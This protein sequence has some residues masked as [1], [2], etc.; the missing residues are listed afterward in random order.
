MEQPERKYGW[1]RYGP[2]TR[3]MIAGLAINAI[4][5]LVLGAILGEVGAFLVAAP[6]ALLALMFVGWAFAGP[7]IDDD[8]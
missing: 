3:V 5:F 8:E 1:D 7:D 4:V 6:S 2:I